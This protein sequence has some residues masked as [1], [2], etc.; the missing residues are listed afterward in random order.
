MFWL[1]KLLFVSSILTDDLVKLV[2]VLF[3]NKFDVIEIQ[4]ASDR[5]TVFLIGES[6]VFIPQKSVKYFTHLATREEEV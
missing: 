2:F 6:L 5:I 3:F 4:F 1:M